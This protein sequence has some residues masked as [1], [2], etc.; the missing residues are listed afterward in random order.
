[1]QTPSAK[2]TTQFVVGLVLAVLAYLTQDQ[3]WVDGLPPWAA[4]IVAQ[5]LAAVV[6]YMKRETNPAPSSFDR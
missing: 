6:A 5:I 1:V 4:P 2:V 3:S